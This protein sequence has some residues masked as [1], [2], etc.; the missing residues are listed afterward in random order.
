MNLFWLKLK[1]PNWLVSKEI[2]KDDKIVNAYKTYMFKIVSY[3]NSNSSDIQQEVDKVFEL[4]KKITMVQVNENLKRNS[5]F[6]NL[7]LQLVEQ[8][9]HDVIIIMILIYHR[10]YFILFYVCFVNK[11]SWTKLISEGIYKSFGDDLTIHVNETILVDDWSFLESA[12]QIYKEY[13]ATRRRDL[14]NLLIWKFVKEKV[15]LLS[16]K[17]KNIKL[18]YDKVLKGTNELPSSTLTC[19]NYVIDFMEY[20]VG[21]VYVDKYFNGESKESVIS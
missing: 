9:L 7:T 2:Y 10:K 20:A 5:T 14:D 18:D 21:R 16:K 12:I 4:E 1:Q 15:G 13:N 8:K 11:F 6:T 19:S 3:M 17:F